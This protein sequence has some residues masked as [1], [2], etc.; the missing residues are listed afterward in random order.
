MGIP[1]RKEV[2]KQLRRPLLGD[3]AGRLLLA[4]DRPV[5]GLAID[6]SMAG[7]RILAREEL[8]P[9]TQLSLAFEGRAVILV[10]VWCQEDGTRRGTYACGLLTLDPTIDLE[11][12]FVAIG[13][14]EPT[15]DTEA[16]LDTLE[17]VRPGDD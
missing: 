11:R 4:N 16:W 17:L 15:P 6:V 10:V 8:S 5:L 9:G 14:L 7:L 1:L 13:W 2:R 12:H 3:L